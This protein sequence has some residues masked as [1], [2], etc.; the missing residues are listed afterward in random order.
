MAP[1]KPVPVMVT[2]V[3]PLVDPVVGVKVVTVGG[4]TKL[5]SLALVPVP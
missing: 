4:A 3:P 5:K 1:A 2:V